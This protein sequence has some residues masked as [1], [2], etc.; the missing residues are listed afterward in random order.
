MKIKK[1]EIVLF[2]FILLFTL[3]FLG[4]CANWF[5]KSGISLPALLFY[6]LFW[7]PLFFIAVAVGVGVFTNQ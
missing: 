3:F 6:V 1:K 4:I 7:V 5:V 2:G